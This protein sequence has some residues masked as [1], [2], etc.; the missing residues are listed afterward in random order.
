LARN[1]SA[2]G[3]A[4]LEAGGHSSASSTATASA[5][6]APGESTASASSGGVDGQVGR[7]RSFADGKASAAGGQGSGSKATPKAE[8][9]EKSGSDNK[10]VQVAGAVAITI[11]DISQRA[12]I[13]GGLTIASGG[14]LGVI[15]K[16]NTD[17]TANADG[18][19]VTTGPATGTSVG[20]AVALN[21]AFLT[22]E[23]S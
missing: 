7:E 21:L 14:A 23:A 5:A 8:T 3:A 13:P 4:N 20:A 19:A 16:G 2:G 22:T 10:P 17:S 15:A 12:T 11:S 1:L 18:A 9:S 6:G